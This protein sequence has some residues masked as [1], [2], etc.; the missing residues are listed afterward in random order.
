M[1][2]SENE[3]VVEEA[4]LSI[5][6]SFEIHKSFEASIKIDDIATTSANSVNVRRSSRNPMT[7]EAEFDVDVDVGVEVADASNPHSKLATGNNANGEATK[8]ANP[9]RRRSIL[10][11]SSRRKSI[12]QQA[13]DNDHASGVYSATDPEHRTKSQRRR[14]ISDRFRSS[15]AESNDASLPMEAPPSVL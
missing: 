4:T 9:A 7:H 12:N 15:S 2:R 14:S 11:G 10:S 3:G 5:E 8:P 13:D 6:K 1:N